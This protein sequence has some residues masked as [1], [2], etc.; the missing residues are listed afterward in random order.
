MNDMRTLIKIILRPPI[1]SILGVLPVSALE[2]I[3]RLRRSFLDYL[4]PGRQF[5]Y[6]KYLGNLTVN[7]DTTYQIEREWLTGRYEPEM[8][9][10]IDHLVKPGDICFDVGANAGA[11]ALALAK[12]TGLNGRVYAIEPGKIVFQRLCANIE[13]NPQFQDIIRP[14]RIAFSNSREMRTWVEDPKN[15]GNASFV[16]LDQGQQEQF[17]LVPMDDFVLSEKVARVDFVKIDVEGLEYEVISGAL[18]T[19]ERFEPIL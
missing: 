10:A 13:L 8:L 3:V 1:R 18:T 19:I 11:V 4:P 16:M 17:D 15:P 9:A 7:I 12:R 2:R 5:R 14:F 6:K